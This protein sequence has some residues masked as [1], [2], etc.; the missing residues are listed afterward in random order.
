[1][2]AG[3]PWAVRPA[4]RM[5]A[6]G[7][8][9]ARCCA[10]AAAL[11]KHSDVLAIV[12]PGGER[13]CGRFQAAGVGVLSETEQGN[14]RF[15]GAVLDDYQLDAGDVSRWRGSVRGPLVQIIDFGA[16]L[17]GI[18]L[19]VNA[20]PG[21]AGDGLGGIPALLGAQFAMLAAPY[22][23][24][25]RASI[26]P[27]VDRVV[28]GI[29]WIDRLGATERVLAALARALPGVKVD[30]L[31]GSQSPNAGAVAAMTGGH[32][33]WQL[34]LDADRPWQLLDSADM[35]VSGGGQGLLER[36]A[37]GV[38][39]L[40][41]TVAD[42]QKPLLAGAAAA[43]AV[44]DLGDFAD[45]SVDRIASEVGALAGDMERRSSLSR[46]AQ[47]LVDGN[48][49]VRVAARLHELASRSN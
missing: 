12:E 35:A 40:A 43:G 22:T 11:A 19:A 24:R 8:H 30:V 49:A 18:D 25:G 10:L 9:V 15:A 38:P 33:G 27:Q 26:G 28:V 36:L 41:L 42:N 32:A 3:L 48:G 34:H 29:G 44:V 5:E 16:P 7:G 4:T 14:R 17:K 39:T 23:G 31:L 45:A 46:A 1:M 20:T 21:M 13:W 6:G 2:T 37:F 47:A